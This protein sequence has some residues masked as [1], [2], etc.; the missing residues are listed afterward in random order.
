MLDTERIAQQAGMAACADHGFNMTIEIAMQ[1]LGR[2]SRDAD[3]FLSQQFGPTFDAAAVRERFKARY[4]EALFSNGI[5]VKAGLHTM[6]D[7]LESIP[8]PK[9][10]AT[11]TRHDMARKKLE[12]V[13]VLHRFPHVIGGDQVVNGKPAPDIF[14]E[15]ASRLGVQPKH[16][17][18]LEDS[19]A[20]VRAALAAGMTPIMIPDLKPPT[21]ELLSHGITVCPSLEAAA[22]H[23][24]AKGG[25]KAPLI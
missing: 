2:N 16:C 25:F 23:L 12:S 20:G 3:I 15:A 1:L 11:S 22:R 14:L 6:L 17:V 13:N 5:P 21:T 7:W 8:L 24:A 19:E 9:A 10:V 4:E 18:V